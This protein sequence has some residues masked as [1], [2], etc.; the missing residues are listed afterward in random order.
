ML[1]IGGASFEHG[2]Q[3][4]AVVRRAIPAARGQIKSLLSGVTLPFSE[5]LPPDAQ[6]PRTKDS[7]D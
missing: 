6:N 1:T 3:L 5:A 2:D 7:A 4:S